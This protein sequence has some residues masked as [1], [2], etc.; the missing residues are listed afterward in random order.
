MSDARAPGAVSGL[1]TDAGLPPL[2]P[3]AR[4]VVAGAVSRCEAV[5]RVTPGFRPVALDVHVP[6]AASA[7]GD[8]GGGV[9]LVV[10]AHGGGWEQGDR[11]DTP[12]NWPPG[13]LFEA[14]VAAGLAVATLDYRFSGEA[15]FPA[16]FDDVRAGVRYLRAVAPALGVDG[17]RIAV[18]GESAGGQ[19]AALLALAGTGVDVDG[20]GVGATHPASGPVG[21]VG[22]AFAGP[23]QAAALLY[24]P[25]DFTPAA[26]PIS[27]AFPE[28]EGGADDRMLGGP[29]TE[30]PAVAAAASPV[31][32]AR[33]DA[34]PVLL[35]HGDADSIVRLDQSVRLRDALV[36]AGAPDVALDVVA[37]AEHCFEGVDPVPP[38][39]RAVAFLAARIAG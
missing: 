24:P 4:G 39:E 18:M 34:P 33:P 11:R 14:C 38:L 27:S 1:L 17:S 26:A 2:P 10:W 28:A 29:A 6:E 31:T 20:L 30:R 36:A 16:A 5:Y 12:D 3:A 13:W 32:Y 37:G 7:P 35:L 19:L 22:D 23:V 21:E 15:A 8:T 9:G 25:T